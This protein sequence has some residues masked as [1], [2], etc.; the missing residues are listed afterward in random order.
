MRF[1]LYFT[2]ENTQIPIQYRKS[3]L[4]YFKASLSDYNNKYYKKFYNEKDNII[5][6][7]TYSIYFKNPKI[8][9]DQIT[10]EDKK[11][12]LNI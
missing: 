12:E 3:I 2:I 5:K 6:P 7:Y 4:S 1:K 8:E 10:I 11:F 9:Q